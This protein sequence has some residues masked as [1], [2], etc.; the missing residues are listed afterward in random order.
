MK[1]VV[2][3]LA[4]LLAACGGGA[5]TG[6]GPEPV[7]TATSTRTTRSSSVLTAQEITER[8]PD[9]TDLYIAIQSLRPQFLRTRGATSMQ[10]S[11]DPVRV[12]VGGVSAGGIEYLR[13]LKPAEIMLVRL[14]SPSDATTQYGTGHTAGAL[15]VELKRGG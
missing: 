15:V 7:S 8:A 13:N 3:A 4:L 14:L 9:A 10:G 11:S 1:Y 6:R 5:A 2:V 12:Y